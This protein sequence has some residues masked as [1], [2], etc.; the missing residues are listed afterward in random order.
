VADASWLLAAMGGVVGAAAGEIRIQ[1]R[2]AR[3]LE[4]A[5]ASRW[6]AMGG[7]ERYRVGRDLRRGRVIEDP[8]LGFQVAAALREQ[9]E[10]RWLL[11]VCGVL[12]LL[13]VLLAALALAGGS[14]ALAAV[15]A[16]IAA[17]FLALPL[18]QRHVRRRLGEAEDANR[19]ALYEA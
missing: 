7:F 18:W 11:W 8:G 1:R 10:R 17:G 2:V 19:R 12:G 16:V 14:V 15:E 4:K 6:D 3:Q 5:E 13:F 9:L